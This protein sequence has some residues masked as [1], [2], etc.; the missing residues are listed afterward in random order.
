MSTRKCGIIC[1]SCSLAQGFLRVCSQIVEQ[2]GNERDSRQKPI[3]I[4]GTAVLG[5][6]LVCLHANLSSW[7]KSSEMLHIYYCYRQE[8]FLGQIYS[9]RAVS[10]RHITRNV[11]RIVWWQMIN[12]VFSLVFTINGG[13]SH[14]SLLY[15]QMISQRADI[16][17]HTRCEFQTIPHWW[18][19]FLARSLLQYKSWCLWL[20]VCLWQQSAALTIHVNIE[21]SY[22]K[23]EA[24][25]SSHVYYLQSNTANYMVCIAN[26]LF[27]LARLDHSCIWQS[28]GIEDRAG[29]TTDVLACVSILQ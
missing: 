28:L 8:T 24:K 17:G 20:W 2:L 15:G 29:K 13:I 4:P 19:D 25:A 23:T 16:L 18:Y 9:E 27:S 21:F 26:R 10:M 7:G 14:M 22:V 6:H 3:E 12:Y 5:R 11:W 1:F